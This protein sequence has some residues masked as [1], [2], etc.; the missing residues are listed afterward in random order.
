MQKMVLPAA[1]CL[2]L[3]M[4]ASFISKNGANKFYYIVVDKD[5]YD[6]SVFDDKGWLVTYPVV[7]GSNDLGDKLMEGDRKTPEGTFTVIEKRVHPK[8]DRMLMLDYPNEES[9]DKFNQRKVQGLIPQSAKIGG[10]IG[11]H[12]TWPHED[13]SVNRYNNWTNG[14]ISLRNKD[15][16][17]LF[18][19]IPVG[20]KVTI[21]K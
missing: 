13:F 9:Y 8:W 10:G 19:A 20:T 11:I 15:V 3:L 12:G 1:L 4:N 14:C 7:F 2:L 6:L 5:R 21:R 17:E 16:E 18:N